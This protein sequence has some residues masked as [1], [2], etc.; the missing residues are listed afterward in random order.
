MLA[1][2]VFLVGGLALIVWG[3]ERFTD[4]AL[5]VARRFAVSAFWIGAVLSGF[6]PENLAAGIAAAVGGLPQIA[7]GTV[8]GSAIFMLTGGL[9]AALLL[10]PMDVRI[11]RAGAWAMLG[12]LALFALVI[13]DGSVTRPEAIVLAAAAVGAMVWLYYRSPT[14]RP[15]ADADDDQEKERPPSTPAVVGRLILGIV[16]ILLGAE[17]LVS[18][19]RALLAT[20]GLSET[21]LGM[22]V[23]G[24]GESLEE[25]AR[26]VVPARRGHP[27]LALGN[28]VGT[29]VVLVLFNLG[30][31]ALV[32]PL[33]ADPL[34]LA[35]HAPYLGA[36]AVVI[37]TAFLVAKRLG[38]ALG[39]GLI[40]AYVVY[41]GLNVAWL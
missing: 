38:R 21:F 22:T 8:I 18:G 25:T 26:M 4:G 13:F 6:E 37:A 19:S 7:L 16:A 10:V 31:I 23:V 3:A 28:V 2:I 39:A 30:V 29:L 12:A 36:C 35:F 27:E 33:A 20:T 34:V 40:A 5:G 14:F 9:G 15:P 32:R 17:A 24:L 41:L 1:G 11:P